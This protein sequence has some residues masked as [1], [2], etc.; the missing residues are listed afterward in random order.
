[1]GTYEG[2]QHSLEVKFIGEKVHERFVIGNPFKELYF[3]IPDMMV[4]ALWP[5][6]YKC[7]GSTDPNRSTLF[8][9]NDLYPLTAIVPTKHENRRPGAAMILQTN[10]GMIGT[11]MLN[12]ERFNEIAEEVGSCFRFERL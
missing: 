11:R 9:P 8:V 5:I 1:M 10:L 7:I 4:Y 12:T 2:V 6:E 3:G